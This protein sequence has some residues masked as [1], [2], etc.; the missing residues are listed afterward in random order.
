MKPKTRR[1]FLKQSAFVVGAIHA[2]AF[3]KSKELGLMA[4]SRPVELH[5][6][7]VEEG[8]DIRL[9]WVGEKPPSQ[10]AGVSFG[11]PWPQGAVRSG[12]EF[13]LR[14][15]AGD[16]PLQSWP[17]AYWPD[18]SLKWSGFA[19]VVP[20]SLNEAVILSR[21]SSSAQGMVSVKRN[22]A[23][24]VVN[25]GAMSCSIASAHAAAAS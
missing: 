10:A 21:D 24:V 2:E 15:G 18:G 6:P 12:S 3:G 9:S 19:T 13:R 16:L 7:N 4:P 17:L 25:T 20:A 5:A 14:I 8:S 1:D 11:V 23:A 22:G